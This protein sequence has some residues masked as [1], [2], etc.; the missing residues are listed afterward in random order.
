MKF[1]ALN[2]TP[3]T[4]QSSE[5]AEVVRQ[6]PDTDGFYVAVTDPAFADT[7][8]FCEAY[9]IALTDS[10]NCIVVQAKRGELVR[11]ATCV[12]LADDAI[13]VNGKVR[14]HL[15]ARKVSFASKDDALRLTRMEYGG[16]TPLGLSENMLIIIDEK[17]LQREYVV[18]GSG[19]RGSK[20][21]ANTSA[22]AALQNVDIVDIST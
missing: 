20:I 21:L 5:V 2:F 10:A 3:L 16:I 19:V 18:I 1:G 6:V 22:L 8:L 9:E 14:K 17:V 13:D 7:K 11:Y 4:A 12:I 15:Q